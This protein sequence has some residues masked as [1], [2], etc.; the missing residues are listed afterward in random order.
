MKNKVK[1]NVSHL[2]VL[3]FSFCLA[4]I[5][6][7]KVWET[8]SVI[9]Q[10]SSQKSH[11]DNPLC[12]LACHSLLH[13]FLELYALGSVHLWFTQVSLSFLCYFASR[14]STLFLVINLN[15]NTMT[16]SMN[17]Q[18][19]CHIA[20]DISSQTELHI[21]LTLINTTIFPISDSSY[22]TYP[23]PYR[24]FKHISEKTLNQVFSLSFSDN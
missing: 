10:A 12:G 22:L 18:I 9:N 16:A 23:I 1:V 24:A 17:H 15:P 14:T 2:L 21:W 6:Y 19:I 20:L 7:I 4:P 5:L 3:K 11:P 13:F 8:G